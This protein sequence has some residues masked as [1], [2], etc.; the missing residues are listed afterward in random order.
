MTQHRPRLLDLY[1]CAGGAAMGYHR[2]GFDVYGVD[3]DAQPRYPFAFHQGDA[4]V[5]LR[6]LVL[7]EAVPFTH[8]DGTVEWLTLADFDVIHASPP[9]QIYSITNAMTRTDHPDL[10]APTRDVLVAIGKPY[11]IENVPGAPMRD[12]MVLCGSEFGLR[13]NDVDGVPLALRRHR[14]FESNV[15]LF[16]A[17][18]CKHDETRVASIFGWGGGHEAWLSR[19]AG[20]EEGL[21]PACRCGAGTDRR[22]LDG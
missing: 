3:K 10:L 8:R 11:V 21:P 2:A 18:G 20:P 17:G 12:Y 19:L 13:A 7:G 15:W 16:G 6:R 22:S 4:L 9:C 1:S 14:W 5:V